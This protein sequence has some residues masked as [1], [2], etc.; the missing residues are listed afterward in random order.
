MKGKLLSNPTNFA[1]QRSQTSP[2]WKTLT[3]RISP[4]IIFP[5]QSINNSIVK[6]DG[7]KK[8]TLVEISAV[9]KSPARKSCGGFGRRE[10]FTRR[11][12]QEN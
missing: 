4:H 5:E 1:T 10:Y 11:V 8:I 12:Q 9:E 7:Q 3:Y 2:G 6:N